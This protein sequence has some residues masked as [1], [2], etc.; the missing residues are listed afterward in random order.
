MVFDKYIVVIAILAKN[1]SPKRFYFYFLRF[2]FQVH[3]DGAAQEFVIVHLCQPWSEIHNFRFATV[4][5]INGLYAA[6]CFNLLPMFTCMFEAKLKLFGVYKE[7]R[8]QI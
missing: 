3:I 8:A 1:A 4:A 7:W 6:Q 2:H 5:Q